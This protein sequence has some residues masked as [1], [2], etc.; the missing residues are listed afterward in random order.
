[1][2]YYEYGHYTPLFNI[3][4]IR[5]KSYDKLVMLHSGGVFTHFTYSH[6]VFS[7]WIEL[8][9]ILNTFVESVLYAFLEGD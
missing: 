4:V 8:S 3:C 7:H 9:L 1:M 5:C 6:G 2:G